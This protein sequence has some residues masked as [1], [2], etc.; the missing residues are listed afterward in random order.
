MFSELQANTNHL[1]EYKDAYIMDFSETWLMSKD[2][3]SN[4]TISGFGAA[5]RL[6][7]DTKVMGKS[8]GGGV[9]VYINQ[10][11]CN[12]GVHMLSQQ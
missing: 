1:Q 11:W 3:D 4:L 5:V 10:W 7:R 6:D 12:Q 9:C 8:R 2:I